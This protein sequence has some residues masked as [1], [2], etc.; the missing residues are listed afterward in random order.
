[1]IEIFLP[2]VSVGSNTIVSGRI[3][4]D[5]KEFKMNFNSPEIKAYE[6]YLDNVSLE[7]DN[8]NPLY[9]AYVEMDSIRTKKYKITNFSTIS[10]K[11]E[12]T[13]FF[14]TEMKGG[15]DN[16]DFYNLNIY[17]TIDEKNNNVVGI[18]KSQVNIKD[19]MWFLNEQDANDNRV[20]FDKKLKNFSIE[21]ILM[22]HDN[23]RVELQGIIRDS[24]YKDVNLSFEDVSL[25]K[26]LPSMDSLRIA[27]NL[28]GR[29]DFKQNRNIYQPS[30]G[31]TIDSLHVNEISLGNLS[32][33]IEGNENL[34]RFS[35]NSILENEN[36]ENFIASGNIGIL[37]KETLF[38]LD[39]RFN[40]FNL[41]ALS[42]LGGN[43]IS[44]IRG[45]ASGTA[46]FAGTLKNPR[47]DGRLFLDNVGLKVPYLNVDYEFDQRSIV[48]LTENQFRFND[49]RMTDTKNGTK[50]FLTGSIKHQNFKNWVLDL[51]I[52]SD[53]LLVLDTKDS[54]DAIYY[55]TAFI[56]GSASLKG[57]TNALLITVDAES[58][59]GT[60][61]KIP[62]SS[63]SGVGNNSFITFLSPKEKYNQDKGIIAPV[64]NNAGLELQFNLKVTPEAEVE[65][66]IDKNTGHALKGKGNG[67]IRLEI[68]TLG[69]FNMFG[70]YDVTEGEYNFKYGGII[71]KKFSV[72][73]GSNISWDGDPIRA[74]LNIDAVY[75][76][77]AN[78]AVLQDNASFNRKVPVE[79]VI[80]LTGSLTNPEPD[81]TINFPTVSSVLKSELQV[82]LDD[83][84]TRVNQALSLLGTGN[85]LS[86]DNAGTAVY[87]SLFERASGLFNDLFQDEDGKFTVALD[88]QMADRT[89]T[90]ETNSQFGIAITTQ[91]SD[92]ISID[93]KV[94]VPV[95]GVNQSVIVGNVEV[96]Y[97]VN[98]D[99]TL[100]L[101]VF[102]RENDI[103]YIGEGIG[104][105]Q[106]LGVSYEVDFDTL[107]ELWFKIFNI[108]T[109]AE[110]N[111]ASDE[112]PDSDL[113]PDFIQWTQERRKRP[114]NTKTEQQRVPESE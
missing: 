75:K 47:I 9:N 26:L 107:R 54:D 5:S 46:G 62:I 104:Y 103:N 1:L 39:F 82:R 85:F 20:V 55:G 10:V 66:I 31:I 3:T 51:N 8:Q 32:L 78:P 15:V 49:A 21:N 110:K 25:G 2:E 42:P 57:P 92:R 43:V 97:R 99:G 94:G 83:R 27:G 23:Q 53:N 69:K 77:Q 59:K 30:A 88:Y 45:F 72:K 112:V 65:I 41:G 28:N 68:S 93:G 18:K 36:V 38:D 86:A 67:D 14:R 52:K 91:L 95:G 113:S 111:N 19:Y 98:D 63:A 16:K 64:V 58:K 24:T 17:H 76:T 34:N 22:T 13:L 33:D 96:K 90:A 102:N 79:V 71:D 106:G 12:D 84:D 108:K 89:P 60:N 80:N 7:I 4:S 44:K 70:T 61:I 109:E 56:A 29:I 100:N 35:V 101:R 6:N 114:E 81:F 73:K 37:N 105:T 48:D 74:R 87:G 40:K 50:G 11:L